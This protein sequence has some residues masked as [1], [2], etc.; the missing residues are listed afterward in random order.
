[1]KHLLSILFLFGIVSI[2]AQTEVTAQVSSNE[3]SV[4][5]YVNYVL[6]IVNP[7]AKGQPKL[8]MPDF[9]GFDVINQSQQQGTNAS[10][11]FGSQSKVEVYVNITVTLKP[12]KAGTYTIKPARLSFGKK[13]YKTEELTV[14]VG[15]SAS[16]KN[17]PDKPMFAKILVSKRRAYLGEPILATYKIYSRFPFEDVNDYEQGE[18]D[19]FQTKT[20][21]DALKGQKIKLGNEVINGKNYQTI[22]LR[23]VVL[24]A[25]ETGELKI[26]P[27]KI[28]GYAQVDFFRSYSDL[29][30]SNEPVITILDLPNKP[31]NF[32]G[33]VG[34]F[35]LVASMGKTK[36]EAGEAFDL[37]IKI[38]GKG[39]THLL[40]EPFLNLPP[41][42]EIYGDPE[43]KDDTN[44]SGEGAKGSI[45]Y[46]YVIRA[47]TRGDYTLG[48]FKL[49]YFNPVTGN[50][51]TAETDSFNL[52]VEGGVLSESKSSNGNKKKP[53]NEI[54]AKE[55]IRF[56][57]KDEPQ[58]YELKDFFF[59]KIGYW[60][61]LC[62][63]LLISSLFIFFVK[64]R[65]NRSDEDIAHINRK[66]ASKMALK[67]LK[68]AKVS[69]QSGN[70]DKFYEE[71]HL[72]MISYL[73]N[74]LNLDLTE[75]NR[76]NIEQ[77]FSEKGLN[78]NLGGS[79]F[80][81]LEQCQMA[82]YAPIDQHADEAL[83]AKAETCI[84]QIQ[85]VMK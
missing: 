1:M 33:A 63:P 40:A 24:F 28:K 41:D 46:N 29:L 75:M 64:R 17:Y 30:N 23:K 51:Q 84:N 42:F 21:Y 77:V 35:D 81:I 16:G 25:L 65:R 18:F 31:K 49:D 59:G 8:T 20:I 53:K 61:V 13:K 47:N 11:G 62:I 82:R 57:V 10:F 4:N 39:N 45:E 76:Q 34:S 52:I 68:N 12:K 73:K 66:Q 67:V 2:H 44:I 38:K 71:L 3:I 79:I 32:N 5:Q 85:K 80:E 72:S 54:E 58:F 6:K 15:K 26:S 43:I 36:I 70:K 37:K 14:T 60:G 48:P 9:E 27:F 69:L 7:P 19:G 22:E 74:K 78:E 50:Y 56:I 83:I 55:D